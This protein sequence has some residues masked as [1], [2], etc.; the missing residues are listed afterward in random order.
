MKRHRTVIVA[1]V[2]LMI[3]GAGVRPASAQRMAKNLYQ[4]GNVPTVIGS[5]AA[6]P[7]SRV[8][9]LPPGDRPT[10]QMP[11]GDHPDGMVEYGHEPY[12]PQLGPH[13]PHFGPM[14][15]HGYDGCDGPCEACGDPSCHGGCCCNNMM[16]GAPPGE[17]FVTVDYLLVR[18]NFSEAVA[19]IEVDDTTQQ[20][21]IF[22]DV[23]QLD[24]DYESSFRIGGGYRMCGCGDE[25]RFLYTRLESSAGE[26]VDVGANI[27]VPYEPGM[28]VG[29]TNVIDAEVDVNSYDIEFAKTIPLG[30]E[31]SCQCDPCGC[32]PPQCPAWDITWSGGIRIADV[33]W[34]RRYAALEADGDLFGG[35]D[36]NMD[37]QGAGAK[38]GLE[39]RR[40]Y[41]HNGWF[42]LY[43][44]GDISLL[45]GD[46]D[47]VSRQQVTEG[48]VTTVT[49]QSLDCTNIIPVTE[50]ELG[51]AGQVTCSTRVSAGYLFSA[52][53]DLGF[54][55]EFEV[56]AA[57]APFPLRYDDAN[58]L[59][60]DGFFARFE[61]A[62]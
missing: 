41:G 33:G 39:G 14:P 50:I 49:I 60:F 17:F 35:A 2:G 47:L 36:V 20:G 28:P 56:E 27:L 16:I 19:F 59:G 51:A 5:A 15:A 53:H 8:E 31:C 46:Y 45:V 54:R 37:F 40:Y 7:E 44:K 30:G 9:E 55:D 29:G 13:G 62:Y 22:R 24:F 26:Q 42:N 38:V 25:I 43:L 11:S 23:H 6:P 61:W 4:N 1:L 58:I 21:V 12:G 52:W 32:C 18:S 57:Q 34:E 10:G 48:A 3:G